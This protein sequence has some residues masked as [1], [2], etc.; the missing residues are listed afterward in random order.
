MIASK[1]IA[2]LK[3]KSSFGP[4]RSMTARGGKKMLQNVMTRRLNNGMRIVP[5]RT[6]F[7]SSKVSGFVLQ[8]PTKLVKIT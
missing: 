6:A 7:K 4:H 5:D 1:N 8:M 3:T 2:Q